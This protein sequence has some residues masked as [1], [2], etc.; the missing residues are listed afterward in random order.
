MILGLIIKHV[1][2]V[3]VVKERQEIDAGESDHSDDPVASTGT[4]VTTVLLY[5]EKQNGLEIHYT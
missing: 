4:T 2:K 3:E 5:D 1:L